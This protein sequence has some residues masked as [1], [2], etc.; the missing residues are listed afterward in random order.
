MPS[1]TVYDVLVVG[2]GFAG[3]YQTYQLLKLG[4]SMKVI[5]K[6]VGR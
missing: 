1:E 2:T 5:E 3:F 6:A 4:L